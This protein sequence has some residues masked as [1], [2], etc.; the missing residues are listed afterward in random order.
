VTVDRCPHCRPTLANRRG[1]GGR[2]IVVLLH[3]VACL[4]PVQRRRAVG[5][6]PWPPVPGPDATAASKYR[7]GSDQ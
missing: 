4:Q 5:P 1:R 3:S 7:H 2:R 6:I